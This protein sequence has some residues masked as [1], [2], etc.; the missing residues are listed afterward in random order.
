MPQTQWISTESQS[1]HPPSHC[2]E[3]SIG[4]WWAKVR[5]ADKCSRCLGQMSI[6]S[7]L[8]D[9]DQTEIGLDHW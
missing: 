7:C 5:G 9:N 4:I 3:D 8:I 1:P 6:V 2:L